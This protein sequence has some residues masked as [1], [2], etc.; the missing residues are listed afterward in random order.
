M[1]SYVNFHFSE[2]QNSNVW[3]YS[4]EDQFVEL[5]E[6]IDQD[7]WEADLTHG[8][9]DFKKDIKKQMRITENLTNSRRGVRKSTLSIDDGKIKI[10][11]YILIYRMIFFIVQLLIY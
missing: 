10:K 7:R 4:S 11:P 6:T 3:Y 2:D 9:E 5:L 1:L 8:I